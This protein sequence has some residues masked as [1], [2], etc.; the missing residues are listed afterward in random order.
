[1]LPPASLEEEEEEEI[2]TNPS[3]LSLAKRVVKDS[4]KST[5][6]SSLFMA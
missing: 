6:G 1:M 5:V 2:K 4:N 3:L